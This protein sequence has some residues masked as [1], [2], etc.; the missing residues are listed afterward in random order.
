[1][2]TS[3]FICSWVDGYLRKREEIERAFQF[4][5]PLENEHE[6]FPSP[7]GRYTL[8]VSRYQN[9][10][11]WNYSRGVVR[12]VASGD[13]IADIRRNIGAFPYAWVYH[14]NGRSYLICGEDYQG[15]TVID[16]DAAHSKTFVP[17]EAERGAGFCWDAIYPSPVGRTMAVDGCYWACPYEWVFFDCPD[18]MSLP[19]VELERIDSPA[20]K[21]SQW[22]DSTTFRCFIEFDVRK[23][24]GVPLDDLP[25]DER[26]RLESNWDL[27]SNRTA[28][29]V[30]RRPSNRP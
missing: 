20:D 17:E 19:Y 24:D 22:V 7:D 18:P 9:P 29:L 2:A 6:M 23:A 3:E 4:A 28:E 27:V 25:E 10:S 30:W 15:Q 26:D 16:L 11:G 14:V 21:P 8:E 1:M 13:V 5:K 12:Q